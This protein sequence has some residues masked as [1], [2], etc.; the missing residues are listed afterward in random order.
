MEAA[1]TVEFETDSYRATVGVAPNADAGTLE[2][3][4][5]IGGA[6]RKTRTLPPSV[7]HVDDVRAAHGKL[8]VVGRTNQRNDLLV[9]YD[10]PSLDLQDVILCRDLAL[11]PSARFAVFERF[12]PR[13]GTPERYRRHVTLLYDVSAT[14]ELNRPEGMP[15][16]GPLGEW[17]MGHPIYPRVPSEGS[18]AY[19]VP[20]TEVSEIKDRD[21]NPPY[22]W[23]HDD[24]H[25]AFVV[26]RG[27][28]ESWETK[29]ILVRIGDDGRP[30]SREAI[31]LVHDFRSP[32]V[33]LSIVD[34]SIRLT[35]G[36]DSYKSIRV[37]GLAKSSRRLSPVQ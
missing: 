20:L 13:F 2:V 10:L 1:T 12:F 4:R 36:R 29:L 6:E 33:D 27:T 37:I 16:N 35:R 22:A 17:S 26:H 9:I 30:E 21:H 24:R 34:D 5:K 18:D 15:V 32:F 11:S 31:D 14:A 7:G 19:L 23:S 25:I 3:T 28:G 8:L